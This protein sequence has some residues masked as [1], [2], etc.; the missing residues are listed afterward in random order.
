MVEPSIR[1]AVLRPSDVMSDRYKTLSQVYYQGWSAM[2][3]GSPSQ[4]VAPL[5]CDDLAKLLSR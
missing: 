2:L 1:Q 4:S 3:R 5:M